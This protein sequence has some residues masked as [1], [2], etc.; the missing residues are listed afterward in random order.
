MAY[1]GKQPT[2]GNFVKLDAIT[3]SATD[4]FNLTNG[5]V[6]YS[7]QSANHCIV[8]LNGVIQEPTS[9]SNVGGFSISGSTIV[10]TSALT[11]NDVID[12]ILVLGDVL[13][14]GT[15]SDAT[16]G[17]AKVTSNLIT[18]ATAETSIAGGDSI[19]IYDDS[20]T[21]LRKMTR[22]NFVSGL[23]G[24]TEA[25]TFRQTSNGT[26]NTTEATITG[27]TRVNS[28]GF[29]KIGT[30]M[31]ES[32]G[33]FTFPSTGIYLINFC[34]NYYFDS[35]ASSENYIYTTLDNSSY[36]VATNTRVAGASSA[37]QGGSGYFIFDVTSTA[38]CK[39][40]FNT[41]ASASIT[42][43]GGSGLNETYVTFIK[44]G[45]T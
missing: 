28:D 4:T 11:S 34:V 12:F 27:M 5:T 21:A 44:L 37:N 30:G 6:A 36:N 39:V 29:D 42:R 17:F 40:K 7:P 23:G 20:A 43:R 35:A 3:T 45:E 32:S 26:S 2:V 8:S 33:I 16:V 25:D 14:I 18:G 38:N 31:S 15:P 22:T 1:I 9:A 19:L 41:Y 13:N 24:L 10:F